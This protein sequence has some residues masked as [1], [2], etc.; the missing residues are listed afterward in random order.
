[1]SV[2]KASFATTVVLAFALAALVVGCFNTKRGQAHTGGRSAV[3][4]HEPTW[5]T[6]GEGGKEIG[7]ALVHDTVRLSCEAKGIGDG[8][9]VTV[10]V[11]E[12]GGGGEHDFVEL[13]NGKAKN[14]IVEV[15]WEVVS[16]EDVA[17]SIS[18]Q[19]IEKDGFVWPKYFFI[20]EYRKTK[21][22]V[23]KLL[24]VSAFLDGQMFAE[25]T[26]EALANRSFT[27]HLS[28]GT[29]RHGK[30]DDTGYVRV[31]SLPIGDTYISVGWEE[32]D[33]EDTSGL[34]AAAYDSIKSAACGKGDC[35]TDTRDKQEY[36]TVKI[37]SQTWMAENLNFKTKNSYCYD[38]DDASCKKYGRLY[39]WDDAVAACPQGWRLSSRED[40]ERLVK[41]AV[42]REL[43]SKIGWAY[44]HIYH[45]S[46]N[47]TDGHGF[48]AL[49]G[50]FSI[51]SFHYAHVGTDGHWW[52]A[53]ESGINKAYCRKIAHCSEDEDGYVNEWSEFKNE[54]RS[55]RC[56]LN[57]GDESNVAAGS[58][59]DARDKRVYRT[60][61]IGK[62]TWMA[63]N[64]SYKT[65]NSWCY[66][67]EES[68]CK[69]YGR[70]YDWNA[71]KSAC[72]AGWHLPDRKEW[73]E[74]LE[75]VGGERNFSITEEEGYF[76]NDA[77][78]KLKSKSGWDKYGDGTDD[79][80][81]TALPGG[82]RYPIGFGTDFNL[83]GHDGYW[84]SAGEYG[85][86]DAYYREIYIRYDYVIEK[87]TDRGYGFSVRCVKDADG[88][89]K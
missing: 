86:T 42:A 13:L 34:D 69:R 11:Y 76:Y 6:A 88:A 67:N 48:S 62:N 60:V 72:P 81:F 2:K 75:A 23:S 1:M 26:G 77:G 71:G 7:S 68:N 35:F 85:A 18:A 63:E 82:E 33:D 61:K 66:E 47:G 56:V 31:D 32:D 5:M 54:G 41:T 53:A 84:W 55:V 45:K 38:G 39:S 25:G 40:W 27:L 15:L 65:K 43:K 9:A 44:D 36:R 17:G 64:L 24:N 10:A 8:E 46:G 80:G 3:A 20:A 87:S 78:K 37:D 12:H 59:T 70:M 28:D 4:L 16:R 51:G 22:P 79:Y 58:V 49:P 74:L 57:T 73:N 50:G 89:R 21:S 14:G 29:T 83:A 30:S 19:Q 52:C